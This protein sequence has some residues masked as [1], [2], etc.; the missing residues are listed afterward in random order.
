MFHL[1]RQVLGDR[2]RQQGIGQAVESARVVEA[3]R[4]VVRELLGERAAGALKKVAL[5]G[6]TLEVLAGSGTLA[7]ELRMREAELREGLKKTTGGNAYRM[8]IFG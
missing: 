7:S 5:R 8:S 1:L 2:L 6:D 3:F 4:Q